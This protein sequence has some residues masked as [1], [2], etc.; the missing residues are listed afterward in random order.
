MHGDPLLL[1]RVWDNLLANALKYS[2]PRRP[3]IIE[4]GGGLQRGADGAPQA[5][6]WV[7]D[8]GVG[9]DPAQAERLFGMFQRLHRAQDFDGTGIGLA[10]ARRIVER[11]GGRIRAEGRPQAGATFTFTLPPL[12]GPPH[13][14]GDVP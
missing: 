11:H 13:V 14:D 4:V 5:V 9:F 10:L 12:D 6:F 8:N 1:A 3:A 2:R 7:R